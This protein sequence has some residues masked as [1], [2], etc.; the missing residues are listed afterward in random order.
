MPRRCDRLSTAVDATTA[1]GSAEFVGKGDPM[2]PNNRVNI[3]NACQ[4]HCGQYKAEL[5]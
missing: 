3:F 1:K 5:R 4:T 2:Q